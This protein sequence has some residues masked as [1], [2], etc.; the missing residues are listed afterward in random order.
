ML[1]TQRGTNSQHGRSQAP[2]APALIAAV[3]RAEA[4]H[5]PDSVEA[6]QRGAD[7]REVLQHGPAERLGRVRREHEVHLRS[8][9]A[10]GRTVSGRRRPLVCRRGLP[11]ECQTGSEAGGGR[12][13][14]FGAA[15]RELRRA[16]WEQSD[17]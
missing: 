9:R 1:A 6:V 3:L 8:G 5:P 12:R 10:E 17:L 7:S 16:C 11:P 13:G 2:E 4:G 15:A 14:P